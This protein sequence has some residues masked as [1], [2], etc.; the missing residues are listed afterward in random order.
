MAPVEPIDWVE[1][2]NACT[3]GQVFRAM[4][5]RVQQD[6]ETRNKQM[7]GRGLA[8]QFEDN[9]RSFDVVAVGSRRDDF[10]RFT[11]S[12]DTIQAHDS[13]GKLIVEGTVTISHT[14]GACQIKR[15]NEA[16]ADDE[17]VFRFKALEALFFSDK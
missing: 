5:T 15:T 12:G 6:I 13:A 11:S 16:I 10:V 3:G 17:W 4:K 2:R 14:S 1:K 8:F 9:G 7:V